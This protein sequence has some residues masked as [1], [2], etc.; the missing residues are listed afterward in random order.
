MMN[1]HLQQAEGKIDTHK[2]YVESAGVLL[3]C[4][5]FNNMDARAICS[6]S[7]N[8]AERYY[9][10]YLGHFTYV[11]LYKLQFVVVVREKIC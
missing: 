10:V 1:D 6:S 2:T 5:L 11:D 4:V 8:R 9:N 3:Q 7:C